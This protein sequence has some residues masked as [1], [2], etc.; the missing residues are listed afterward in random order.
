M[1]VSR[2]GTLGQKNR[3]GAEGMHAQGS[4]EGGTDT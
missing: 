3:V 1:S 2:K 4:Q